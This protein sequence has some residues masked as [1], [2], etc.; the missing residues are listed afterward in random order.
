[1]NGSPAVIVGTAAWKIIVIVLPYIPTHFAFGLYPAYLEHDRTKGPKE[2][3]GTH[4]IMV[5]EFVSAV[6]R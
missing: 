4:L 2:A 1:M 6:S 5:L 3:E